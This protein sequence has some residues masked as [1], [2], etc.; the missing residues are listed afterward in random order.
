[1]GERAAEV[2]AVHGLQG[3]SKCRRG[4]GEKGSEFV[5]RGALTLSTEGVPL[6]G[7]LGPQLAATGRVSQAPFSPLIPRPSFGGCRL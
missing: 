5:F 3:A 4:C 2:T 7:R 6:M 1:M